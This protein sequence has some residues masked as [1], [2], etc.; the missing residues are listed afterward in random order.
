MKR[1]KVGRPNHPS[2]CFN[3]RR[4]I[5]CSTCCWII[6]AVRMK[7]RGKE[8]WGEG[9]THSRRRRPSLQRGGH[10]LFCVFLFFFY[11]YIY[12][13]LILSLFFKRDGLPLL[14]LSPAK[15][16][17]PLKDQQPGSETAGH[18]AAHYTSHSNTITG[19]S[20]T[21]STLRPLASHRAPS[22]HLSPWRRS[23]GL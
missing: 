9:Q 3:I 10:L 23:A 14:V 22:Y 8:S 18:A 5:S 13:H 15:Q 20:S 2:V 7:G 11:F 16:E 12:R 21:N 1:L 19:S 6:N 17:V 4:S